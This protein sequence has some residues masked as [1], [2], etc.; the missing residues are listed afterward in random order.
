MGGGGGRVVRSLRKCRQWSGEII[1]AL[2]TRFVEC[3]NACVVKIWLV[4]DGKTSGGGVAVWE[5]TCFVV[6]VIGTCEK[7]K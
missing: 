4:V 3:V 6:G 5:A 7:G 1:I 2:K